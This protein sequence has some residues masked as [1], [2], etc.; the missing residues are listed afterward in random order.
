M[1][2]GA[3][4]LVEQVLNAVNAEPTSARV[5]EQ[6]GSVTTWRLAQPGFEYGPGS[7]GQGGT[8]LAPSL[9]DHRQMGADSEQ[10]IFTFE[11]IHLREPKARLRRRQYECM[12]APA[13]PRTS[14]GRGQ[15][16]I[17]FRA[18]EE[19]HEGTR[20]ALARNREN[21]L[22]VGSQKEWTPGFSKSCPPGSPSARDLFS[23]LE[24]S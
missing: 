15:Q 8:T 23:V 2:S 18:R 24:P 22:D 5:G 1:G 13:G 7:F 3:T 19:A 6:D 16:R 9:A 12:I 14:I 4:M 11:S 10:D 21:A 17:H 20:E